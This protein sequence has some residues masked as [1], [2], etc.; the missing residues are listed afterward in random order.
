MKAN[1]LFFD[2]KPARE[3]PWTERLWVYDLRTNKHFTLKMKP[4]QRTDLDHF[5]ACYR[6]GEL[7]KRESTWSPENDGG[8][9]R[10]FEYDELAK[11]DKLNLDLL[12]L[13]DTALEDSESLPQPEILA[14]AIVEDLQ[15]ALDAFQTIAWELE[16]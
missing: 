8:R 9:W 10:A 7:H 14:A 11:R 4:M 3:R 12:W 15:A 16:P 5:V 6:P 2:A 1:V 13:K